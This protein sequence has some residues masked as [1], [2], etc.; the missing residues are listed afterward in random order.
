MSF[1]PVPGSKVRIG[2]ARWN[3][4]DRRTR[5]GSC[6]PTE[7]ARYWRRQEGSFE[8]NHRMPAGK[9]EPLSRAPAPWRFAGAIALV[10]GAVLLLRP[11]EAATARAAY[12]TV[13]PTVM[14]TSLILGEGPGIA[15]AL[16]GVLLVERA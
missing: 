10:W 14:L 8:A 15:G 2:G 13:Y 3:W 5:A 9:L 1:D 4:A 12:L 11:L 7:Q 6:L 16:F